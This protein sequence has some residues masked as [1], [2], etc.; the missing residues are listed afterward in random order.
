MP[1]NPHDHYLCAACLDGPRGIAGHDG[2]FQAAPAGSP[3]EFECA[4][5]GARWLRRYAGSGNFEWAR[6]ESP[7]AG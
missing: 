4:K 1:P 3:A 6:R 2:I 5:C 7:V